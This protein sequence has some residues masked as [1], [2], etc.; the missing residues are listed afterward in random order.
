MTTTAFVVSKQPYGSAQDGETRITRLLVAA[1]AQACTVKVVALSDEPA[2]DAPVEVLEV[3]KP[4]VR[5]ARLGARSLL[6]RRSLLHERFAPPELRRALERVDADAFIA[7]RAYMAQA[8]ID[9]GRRAPRDRLVVLVDVLE[10]TVMRRRRSRLRPLLSLEAARTRRDEVRCARAASARAYLSDTELTEIAGEAGP[11]P[12]LD[13]VLPVAETPAPLDEAAAVFVGDRSWPPNA[14]ALER[15]LALWPQIRSRAPG[16]KLLVVGRPG[17]G[18]GRPREEGVAVL[19]F[20]DDL[21]AV[22]RSSA[23]L[24]APIPIGGG[25][26]VKVLDAARHGLPI[27]GSPEAVGSVG[28]YLPVAPSPSDAEFVGDA[29]A[30]LA[31]PKLR[32]DRGRTLYAANEELARGGFVEEQIAALI[33]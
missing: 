8:P 15:L 7:R 1:A 33:R 25:V 17:P 13:L 3:P 5:M 6:A 11:G 24:L 29:A 19:G 32:R 27:V 28:E 16:S 14:E 30:L 9:A 4:P 31:D 18:E 21:D 12:R 23:V 10:S 22:M 26:R 2:R 20:V